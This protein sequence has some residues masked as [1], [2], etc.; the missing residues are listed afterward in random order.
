MRYLKKY[1][2]NESKSDMEMRYEIE[3]LCDNCLAYLM[4][5]GY[6]YNVIVRG[7]HIEIFISHNNKMV[8]GLIKDEIDD[9]IPLYEILLAKYDLFYC[10][11]ACSVSDR[12]MPENTVIGND[13]ILSDEFIEEFG[14]QYLSQLRIGIRKF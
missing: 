8:G 13:E 4:D 1:K 10:G 9:I 12:E 5:K 11:V 6:I 2:I 14:D 7:N 3:E